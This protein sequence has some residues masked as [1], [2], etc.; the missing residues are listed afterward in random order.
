MTIDTLL[1]VALVILGLV[2][3]V[4]LTGIVA[5]VS[6]LQDRLK[7]LHPLPLLG[8]EEKEG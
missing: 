2:C 6:D 7:R 5:D 1:L 4:K 8:R 3:T